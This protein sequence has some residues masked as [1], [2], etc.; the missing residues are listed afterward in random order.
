MGVQ[1]GHINLLLGTDNSTPQLLPDVKYTS[2]TRTNIV[3]TLLNLSTNPQIQYG[4]SILI[5][6]AG[7]GAVYHCKDYPAYDF[8]ADQ[9]TIEALCPVDR[10][11]IASDKDKRIPDI[12]D[13]E[14]STILSEI[15]RTRGHHITVI[16]DCCHSAGATRMIPKLGPGDRVRRAQELDAPYAIADMFAAGEKRLGELKDG[17]GFLRYKSISAGDW[18]EE[19]KKAHVLLAA[20]RSYGLAKE[21]RD[22]VNNAYRGVFTQA[23]LHKL[24]EAA[25]VGE[26]PTYVDLAKHLTQIPLDLYP[27]VNGDYRNMQ[28]WFTV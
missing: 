28:L 16:L 19:S 8:P 9:G 13:R 4:D 15:C 5:Y 20:C 22:L 27:V 18:K 12:C 21:A 23:L 7:H 14:F 3:D 24:G 10:N 6:F 17:H 25:N 1:P 2:A 26:L 11:P